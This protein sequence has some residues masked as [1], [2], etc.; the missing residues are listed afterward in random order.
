MSHSELVALLKVGGAIL[1]VVVAALSV[2]GVFNLSEWWRE[3][4][5][6][7][8]GPFMPIM[9]TRRKDLR[10]EETVTTM[11]YVAT[12]LYGWHLDGKPKRQVPNRAK[13]EELLMQAVADIDIYPQRA[14]FH[15]RFAKHIISVPEQNPALQPGRELAVIRPQ[16]PQKGGT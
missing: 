5:M 2:W 6:R 7:K 4:S 11:R 13:A 16:A 15:A 12:S 3:R 1:F 9:P 10:R 8:R 14:L